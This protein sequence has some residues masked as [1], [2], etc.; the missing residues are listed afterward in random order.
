LPG[1]DV[2]VKHFPNEPDFS[3]DEN[4]I[5]TFGTFENDRWIAVSC[6]LKNNQKRQNYYGPALIFLS[7]FTSRE[8]V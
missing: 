7:T 8:K 5:N 4:I 2:P 6:N 1:A 3:R